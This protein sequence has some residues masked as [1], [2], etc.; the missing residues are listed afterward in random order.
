MNPLPTNKPLRILGIVN[1]PWDPRLGAARV[2]ID[3]TEEWRKAGHIVE[4]F[5][6]TDAF[7]VPTSSRGFSALRQIFFPRHAAR[8]VK[9][10]AQRFD[11]ID[12]LIG[13]LPYSKASLGFRGLLVARSVGLPQLYEV[14]TKLTRR[15][16]PDQPKGKILGRVFYR[17]ILRRLKK[18]SET[19]MR[20]CDLLNLPNE[21]EVRALAV[22]PRYDKPAIV[23][24]YGLNNRQRDKFARAAQSPEVRLAAKKISFIGMWGLRKG[25]RDWPGIIR[26]ISAEIPDAQFLFLGTMVDQ[27]SVVREL[28]TAHSERVHCVP[29]Y[30]PKELPQLLSDC[31]IGIFPSYIEGFGLAILEQLAGGIPTI[32]YDVSGPRQILGDDAGLLLTPVGDVSAI[33]ARAATILRM[34]S[35]E[36]TV[37]SSESRSLADRFRWEQIAAGTIREYHAALEKL[38]RAIVFTQPF[39]LAHAGG[40]P[41]I[42]RSLLED[43]PLSTLAVCTSPA[44]PAMHYQGGEIH[45]PF[46]PDFGRIERSRLA[47]LPP[48]V[49]PLFRRRFTR[50]L[51]K[52]VRDVQARA[53]H[54]VAHGGP[55]FYFAYTI[56]K[57]LGLPFVLQVHDDV[58]YTG[59]DQLPARTM[60]RYL[61]EAWREARAR[62]VISPELGNEYNK[63]YGAREFVTVTDSL[64]SIRDQPRPRAKE[65]R[66]Y[67]MGLFHLGYEPNL[68]ALIQALDLL[69]NHLTAGHTPSITL[70]CDYLRPA[71]RQKSSAIRVLPFGTEADVQSDLTAA[72]CLYLPLQFG[73]QDWPFGAYSLSTKMVTYLGSGIPILYHG[74]AGTAVCNLLAQHQAAALATSLEPAHIADV[75]ADL[76]DSNGQVLATNALR[77]ARAQFLRSQ[78][79]S[80]FWDRLN[81][82]VN[83]TA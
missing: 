15:R 39:S 57:K 4:K 13:T 77:L 83:E 76:L 70:R 14:F 26:A 37:L 74:P 62:F 27:E 60:S 72:D 73:E 41:R 19:A 59:A 32:A 65:L 35:A 36:Y 49:T 7:P 40:G 1:L 2:W 63:R 71:M 20:T 23:Q 25:S 8:Y 29:S 43:A 38:R 79:H 47:S 54:S 30:D 46:R 66:I 52:I 48:V 10:H 67:F 6:L 5:C 18:D 11:V 51:E 81:R 31:A 42:M 50:R 64:D 24:P 53:I 9:L 68:E 21:D 22:M 33:A 78:Q 12:A 80:K 16:W 3:L 58:T 44:P 28:G 45:L 82:C 56:S 75:L 34:T 55:D 69:P 61:G 17:F